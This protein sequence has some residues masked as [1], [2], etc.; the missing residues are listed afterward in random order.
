MFIF[1]PQP[2]LR[3]AMAFCYS[4]QILQSI[5]LSIAISRLDPGVWRRLIHF[6]ISRVK[7][8]R[9]GTRGGRRRSCTP[10]S[11]TTFLHR[12]NNFCAT[13]SLESTFYS[14]RYQRTLFIQLIYNFYVSPITIFPQIA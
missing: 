2:Y 3:P 8:T 9:R 1:K 4:R 11:S 6:G 14:P 7:P 5:S 12:T 10:P 13:P